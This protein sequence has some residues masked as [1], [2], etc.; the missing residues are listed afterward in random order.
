MVGG[1]REGRVR[2]GRATY[3]YGNSFV[4]G[5]EMGNMCYL[6]GYSLLS[7]LKLTAF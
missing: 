3:N 7:C 2:W 5:H 1:K 6:D 4:A